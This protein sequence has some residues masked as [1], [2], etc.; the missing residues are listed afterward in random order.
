MDKRGSL[1]PIN[2]LCPIV[3]IT[4]KNVNALLLGNAQLIT[5]VVA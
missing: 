4:S 2:L 3:K 1:D 5:V